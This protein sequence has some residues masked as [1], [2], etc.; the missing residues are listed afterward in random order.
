MRVLHFTRLPSTICHADY[1][2]SNLRFEDNRVV[3]VYDFDVAFRAPRLLD[4]GGVVTRFSPAGR[5][6]HSDV[7]T[8]AHFLRAYHAVSPLQPQEWEALPTF[9]RWRLVRD[10]VAYYDRWWFVV[11]DTCHFLFDGGA[12]AIVEA[13]RG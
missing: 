1:R 8:G 10:V 3:A 6:V 13:A 9:I 7:E 12:D 4:L 11:A 2:L 5:Q